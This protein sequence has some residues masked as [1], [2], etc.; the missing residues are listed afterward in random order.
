M[1]KGNKSIHCLIPARSGSK[2]IP[3]KNIQLLDG[4]PLIA[5]SIEIALQSKYINHVVV[6]T[7]S[8]EYAQI[9]QEYGA[10]VPFLRPSDIS[11]D[12]STDIEFMRHYLSYLKKEQIPIPDAILHLRPTFPN[13][14]L[15]DLER[16]IETFLDFWDEYD[17]LRSVIPSP[18]SPYKMYHIIDNYLIPLYGRVNNQLEPY[19]LG[20]QLLPPTYLHNGCYDIVKTSVIENNSSSGIR[21]LP[22]LMEDNID[23]DT[24]KDLENARQ[25]INKLNK[26]I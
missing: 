16:A 19:N 4:K 15:S 10:E 25:A 9:A 8:S 12:H 13:R 3:D 22:F 26:S 17:S 7:D 11:Q 21:I 24:P 20:R 2:G 23:I 18:K 1:V 14:R 6:T 5:H